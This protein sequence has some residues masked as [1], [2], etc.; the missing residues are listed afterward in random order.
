MKI[1]LPLLFF[2]IA[3]ISL[4]Q[5]ADPKPV[6]KLIDI[7]GYRL[8]IEVEGKG[9]PKVVFIAGSQAFSFDWSL[10]APFI[11]AVTQTVTYDRPGLAWSDP[12]PMPRTFD[13]DVYELHELLQKAEVSPPYILVGHSIGGFIA[14]KFEM[15]YPGEVKGLV[16]VDATSENSTLFLNNKAQRIRQ[17][18]EGRQIP[19]VKK[20]VDTFTKVP[21][22]KD[23]DDLWKMIGEPKIDAPYDKLPQKIQALRLWAMKQPKYLVADDGLYWAEDFEAVYKDSA[24]SLGNKPLFVITS[25]QDNYPKE[26]GDSARIELV[27]GKLNDQEK[28]TR[29]SLNSKH[30]IT[31]KS[32]HEIHVTEP[33]LVINAIKSVIESVKTGMPLK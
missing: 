20:Q 25:G 8:H 22:Q 4:A 12:G 31:T 1:L 24:Y 27:K 9:S 19:S 30:I 6:G 16:L 3:K 5:A 18:S 17:L 11:A 23:A 33:G 13:Q 7:G 28:M 21:A 32:P 2:A 26:L 14:R 10:V 15:K 29:L